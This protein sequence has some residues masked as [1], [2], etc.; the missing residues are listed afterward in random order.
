MKAGGFYRI[1]FRELRCWHNLENENRNYEAHDKW[2]FISDSSGGVWTATYLWY[3]HHFGKCGTGVTSGWPVLQWWRVVRVGT[4]PEM[5][6]SV[7]RGIGRWMGGS[8][9]W[10]HAD[11]SG[12]GVCT[13]GRKGGQQQ[14][15]GHSLPRRGW[16]ARWRGQVPCWV[17]SKPLAD[18]VPGGVWALYDS[19]LPLS[20]V[21]AW[22]E[23]Q[24]L[25]IRVG[26][27]FVSCS[28]FSPDFG[29]VC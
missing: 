24:I 11:G 1:A 29:F 7:A 26:F 2:D 16:A 28:N 3:W 13:F 4:S 9:S 5:L 18:T 12:D 22:T 6:W 8:W 25:L 10:R 20:G 23:N 21:S 27:S 17:S 15:G 19:F 14:H